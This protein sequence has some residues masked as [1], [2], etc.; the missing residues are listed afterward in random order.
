[1][2]TKT[3]GSHTNASHAGLEP[4]E[5]ASRDEIAA[6]QLSRMQNSFGRAY[7]HSPF[8][9]RHF[10]EHGVHPDDLKSLEDLAKFPFTVKDHLRENYP[11][12][13]FSVPR[14]K[15]ARLHASSGTTGRPTVVGYTQARH[16]HVGAGR[17]ALDLCQRRT[18]R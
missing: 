8:Y 5:T 3:T 6:L 15:L 12:G 18:A 9:R 13:M 10:E 11:F 1:M 2:N 7:E 4:I 17:G 14:E 16:R